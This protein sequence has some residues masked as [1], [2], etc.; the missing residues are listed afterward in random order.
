MERRYAMPPCI[1]EIEA[2]YAGEVSEGIIGKR[3]GLNVK[4]IDVVYCERRECGVFDDLVNATEAQIEY[5]L[6]MKC[7]AIDP[8]KGESV[9]LK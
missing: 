5:F 6:S 9:M 4:R 8:Q 1:A 7:K 2:S 3:G